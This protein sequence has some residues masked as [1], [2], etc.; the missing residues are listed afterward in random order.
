MCKHWNWNWHWDWKYYILLTKGGDIVWVTASTKL[1]ELRMTWSRDKRKALYL[2][3]WNTYDHQNWQSG[4]SWWGKPIFIVTWPFDY[5]VTCQM[6]RNYIC[7]STIPM[8][9]NFGRVITYCQKT[10]HTKSSYLLVTRSRDKCKT[11]Y[12]YFCNIYVYQTWESGN[13]QVGH[14]LQSHVTH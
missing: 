12:L 5:V 10:R 3:F 6:K 1:L 2:P 13:L 14:N 4:N 9:I 11:L 7:T 8:V